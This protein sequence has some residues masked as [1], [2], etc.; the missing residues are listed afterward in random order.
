MAE[1]GFVSLLSTLIP[2]CQDKGQGDG[3]KAVAA[4][5]QTPQHGVGEEDGL[6]GDGAEAWMCQAMK[7]L[8]IKADSKQMQ[9]WED[10]WEAQVQFGAEQL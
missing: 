10:S 2:G 8:L 6:G 4:S 5:L 7:L 9:G 3:S 1:V